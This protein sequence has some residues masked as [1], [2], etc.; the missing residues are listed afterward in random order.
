MG[1]DDGVNN[2][3]GSREEETEAKSNILKEKTVGEEER[4]EN[5]EN[6]VERRWFSV[7]IIESSNHRCF[8]EERES[9]GKGKRKNGEGDGLRELETDKAE[10]LRRGRESRRLE[11]TFQPLV[12]DWKERRGGDE[13]K[14]SE[15]NRGR[16]REG[17]E[18]C[19]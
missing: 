18:G 5:G 12:H 6:R 17:E 10:Q 2:S 8:H 15:E 14:V 7:I 16:E 4:V 11:Q 1:K 19:G 13:K 9:E 3:S